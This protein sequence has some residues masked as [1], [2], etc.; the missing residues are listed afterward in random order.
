[1]IFD[2]TISRINLSNPVVVKVGPQV[3]P[4]IHVDGARG[5]HIVVEWKNNPADMRS[6]R[7][8]IISDDKNAKML[9][10]AAQCGIYAK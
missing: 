4:E 7:K 1:M 2:D 5:L 6:G 8:K 9:M 10:S 3:A